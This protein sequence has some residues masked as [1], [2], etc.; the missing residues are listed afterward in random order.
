MLHSYTLDAR[1]A[2]PYTHSSR[3]MS[4]HAQCTNAKN[5]P[6]GQ[7]ASVDSGDEL[8]MRTSISSTYAPRTAPHVCAALRERERTPAPLAFGGWLR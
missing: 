6:S 4:L 5:E 1:Q 2:F 3:V 7:E 8:V